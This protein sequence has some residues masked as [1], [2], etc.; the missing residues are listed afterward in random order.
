ME[1]L[2]YLAEFRRIT[3]ELRDSDEALAAITGPHP[4][5]GE[6]IE[7]PAHS[8]AEYLHILGNIKKLGE[9]LHHLVLTWPEMSSPGQSLGQ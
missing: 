5:A 2:E 9:D 1:R 8:T 7:I 4:P 3:M 6:T